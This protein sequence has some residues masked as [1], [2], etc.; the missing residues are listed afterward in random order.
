MLHETGQLASFSCNYITTGHMYINIMH[1]KFFLAHL[2]T[3]Y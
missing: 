2:A 3:K 1:V